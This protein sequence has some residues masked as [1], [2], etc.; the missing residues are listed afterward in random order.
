MKDIYILANTRLE[1]KK[2]KTDIINQI[3][4]DLGYTEYKNYANIVW[5]FNYHYRLIFVPASHLSGLIFSNCYLYCAIG[6]PLL[7]FKDRMGINCRQLY[8]I[9]DIIDA[10]K[11]EIFGIPM[12]RVERESL[13]NHY[14]DYSG[15]YHSILTNTTKLVIDNVIFNDPATIVFWNDGT[16]TVVKC[17]EGDIFDKE[18]GLSMAICKKLSGNTGSFNKIFK[19]WIPESEQTQ[20]L[21]NDRYACDNYIQWHPI[22]EGLPKEEGTYLITIDRWSTIVEDWVKD[23]IICNDFYRG[24]FGISTRYYTNLEHKPIIKAW[25]ELPKPYKE[26]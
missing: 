3:K 24:S 23:E 1:L 17:Q 13:K 26:V 6:V 14:I 16:K 8:T 19:R 9:S 25:A 5:L 7:S 15:M 20:E 11:E 4:N 2:Y 10:I 22:K 21:S 12:E 18:K